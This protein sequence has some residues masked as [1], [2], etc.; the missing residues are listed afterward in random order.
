MKYSFSEEKH[1]KSISVIDLNEAGQ[2]SLTEI[3]LV[4]KKDVVTLEGTFNEL[5]NLEYP[6]NPEDYIRVVLKDKE[7]ILEPMMRLRTKFPNILELSRE[8]DREEILNNYSDFSIL[9][10]SDMAKLFTDFYQL[11]ND[12]E[13]PEEHLA[14]LKE[15]VRELEGGEAP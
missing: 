8:R 11:K 13:I 2:V 14:L 7:E 1:K 10:S 15:F 5:M 9:Q 6:G 4:P 12:R 3:P